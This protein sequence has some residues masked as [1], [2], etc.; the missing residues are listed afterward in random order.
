MKFSSGFLASIFFFLA[1]LL[2]VCE[3]FGQQITGSVTGTVTDPAGATVSGAQVRLT[4]IG[5][6]AVA[7]TTSDASG[8]F[9]FL[10]LPP[11]NYSLQVSNTGF[12]SLLCVKGS[13]LK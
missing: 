12:K 5:T 3:C 7:T 10:L 8:N 2:S 4:N 1:T 6:G 13:S 11:G 9:Q